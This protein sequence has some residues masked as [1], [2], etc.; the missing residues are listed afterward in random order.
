[1]LFFYIRHGDPIYDP[2]SLTPLGHEQA[3]AVSKRLAM[4]GLDKIYASTSNRA[5]Q[6]AKPTCELLGLEPELL[7]FAHEDHT[8]CDFSVPMLHGTG[9]TWIWN[10]PEN[11]I[12]LS[13]K[14]VRDLGDKWYNH[15]AFANYNF[16]KGIERIYDETD[17]F[18]ASLGYEHERYSGRY[19]ITRKNSDRI[20]LFAHQG[21]GLAFLSVLLDIPYPQF[22]THFDFCHTGMTVIDFPD[23]CGY[24]VPRVLAHSLDSHLYKE[25]LPTRYNNSKELV[26]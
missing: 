15:P 18:F 23:L 13:S 19:K 25:G 10:E 3:K 1:M 11:R 7:D 2:D 6:T 5:I 14:E 4:Y 20:A 16:Q 17:K 26:F 12:I 8:W 9:I 24:S 21:F 22:C